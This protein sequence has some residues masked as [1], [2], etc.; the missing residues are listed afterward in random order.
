MPSLRLL[1]LFLSTGAGAVAEPSVSGISLSF[2][3]GAAA[4]YAGALV[5]TLG[6]RI[7]D[8]HRSP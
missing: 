6:Y 2:T 5:L 4:L 1:G 8:I 7:V 3:A